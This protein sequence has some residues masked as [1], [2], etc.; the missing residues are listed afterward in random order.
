MAQF[1]REIW[2]RLCLHI[3]WLCHL[4]LGFWYGRV[5]FKMS[6][7]DLFRLKIDSK[8]TLRPTVSKMSALFK[9]T[10]IFVQDDAPSHA[11]MYSAVCKNKWHGPL[12][13]VTWTLLRTSG[14]FISSNFLGG[15]GGDGAKSCFWKL[16]LWMEGLLLSWKGGVTIL[17]TEVFFIII[18]E[19]FVNFQ[20]HHHFAHR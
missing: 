7:S 1:S 14:F 5:L 20:L 2:Q 3:F 4:V 9:K 11:S 18:S 19:M 17:V 6:Q 10:L 16:T 12:R 8:S 13:H 15:C